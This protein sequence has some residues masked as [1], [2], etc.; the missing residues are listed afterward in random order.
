MDSDVTKRLKEVA[1]AK[2]QDTKISKKADMA[3][4]RPH[5][6]TTSRKTGPRVGAAV[7]AAFNYGKSFCTSP[8][9]GGVQEHVIGNTVALAKF[10]KPEYVNLP[11]CG[12]QRLGLKDDGTGEIT[13][14]Y[15]KCGPGSGL[16]VRSRV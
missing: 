6:A 10:R 13:L 5:C 16:S 2:A 11:N 8:R 14:H 15:L 7:A 1:R 4:K 3:S 12:G 9:H